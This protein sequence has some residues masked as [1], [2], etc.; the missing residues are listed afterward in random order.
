MP[1]RVLEANR[2]GRKICRNFWY[3]SAPSSGVGWVGGSVGVMT[4]FLL[5]VVGTAGGVYFG[6][7]IARQYLG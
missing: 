6:R 2:S 7:W 4:A 3:F 1:S 5:S